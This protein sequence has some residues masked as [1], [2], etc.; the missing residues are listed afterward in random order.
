MRRRVGWRCQCGGQVTLKC[1]IRKA[2][3]PSY[4]HR[5]RR[6]RRRRRRRRP[7]GHRRRNDDDVPPPRHPPPR[8]RRR[9]RRQRFRAVWARP[10]ARAGGT[11]FRV[12]WPRLARFPPKKNY[13]NTN[14]E[15]FLRQSKTQPNRWLHCYFIYA[16]VTRPCAGHRRTYRKVR[17]ER[18]GVTHFQ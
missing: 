11:D 3:N 18:S 8:C 6:R 12:Q 5:G 17:R 7:I 13:N 4:P 1:K 14:S 10:G 16:P 15:F 9:R 2:G